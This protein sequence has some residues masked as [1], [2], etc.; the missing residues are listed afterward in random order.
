VL[1]LQLWMTAVTGL[2][3][4]I[5][6]LL[7]SAIADAVSTYS[8]RF[9]STSKIMMH[10]CCSSVNMPEIGALLCAICDTT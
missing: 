6:L 3:L 1:G 2:I 5:E 8:G 9:F 4:P 7:P 10:D